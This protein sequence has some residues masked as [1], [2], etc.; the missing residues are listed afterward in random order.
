MNHHSNRQSFCA[1]VS[2]PPRRAK[3]AQFARIMA[4][5]AFLSSKSEFRSEISLK[6][7]AGA[8][9]SRG[10][11]T[12]PAFII[13]PAPRCQHHAQP[14]QPRHRG[15]QVA[16]CSRSQSLRVLVEKLELA[17]CMSLDCHE[18]RSIRLDLISDSIYII[19]RPGH[20]GTGIPL[21]RELQRKRE[22]HVCTSS[23]ACSC[24]PS[25]HVSGRQRHW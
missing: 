23:A 13:N 21:S 10:T 17:H 19:T 16:C 6:R 11:S 14:K 1:R 3:P 25:V 12:P 2:R 7:P 9:S 24:C 4:P 20:L 8:P 18:N 22:R 15:D 5:K